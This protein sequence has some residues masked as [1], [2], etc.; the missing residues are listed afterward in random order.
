MV[1]MDNF[2]SSLQE[3][4]IKWRLKLGTKGIFSSPI[5]ISTDHL[6]VA[7]LDGTCALLNS[8]DGSNQW[9]RHVESPIFSTAIHIKQFSCIVMAEVRGHISVLS[10]DD[11]RFVSSVVLYCIYLYNLKTDIY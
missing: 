3:K 6:F 5:S 9:L 8:T 2:V 7:T 10:I 11:G 4:G 1:E